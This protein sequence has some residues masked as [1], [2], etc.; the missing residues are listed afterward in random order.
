MNNSFKLISCNEF[1]TFFIKNLQNNKTIY[2]ISISLTEKYNII[3]I[4]DIVDGEFAKIKLKPEEV[5]YISNYISKK[6]IDN[7]KECEKTHNFNIE[8]FLDLFIETI[9]EREKQKGTIKKSDIFRFEVIKKLRHQGFLCNC[10]PGFY[11]E[12]KFYLQQ[13]GRIKDDRTN[14]IILYEQEQKIWEFLYRNKDR[15]GV[16]KTPNIFEYCLKRRIDIRVNGLDEKAIITYI[17][18]LKNGSYQ[19]QINYNGQSKKLTKFFTKEE[20]IDRVIKAR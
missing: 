5:T 20:L 19:I 7:I 1:N 13:N 6:V 9:K 16:E 3:S 12:T 2:S 10:V 14:N 18:D 17:N 8:S 4:T 15:V 11:P